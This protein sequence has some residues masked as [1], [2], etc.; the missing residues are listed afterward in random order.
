MKSKINEKDLIGKK[1]GI[2]TIVSIYKKRVR[3][4][5]MVKCRCECK[6]EKKI[7]FDNIKRGLTSSCGCREG[8]GAGRKR[9]NCP[10]SNF[11]SPYIK[12]TKEI[13]SELY[14]NQKKSIREIGSELFVS[15]TSIHRYMKLYNIPARKTRPR[16]TKTAYLKNTRHVRDYFYE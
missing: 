15:N 8:F 7:R 14:L 12:P 4:N 6:N 11:T 2:L 3:Y 13:L 5:L 16:T 9:Y 1:F 10:K